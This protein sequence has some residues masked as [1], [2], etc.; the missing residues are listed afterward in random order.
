MVRLRRIP[1]I[2]HEL[3]RHILRQRLSSKL[4]VRLDR[5]Y[6]LILARKGE[7][8]VPARLPAVVHKTIVR[9]RP[10]LELKL[11][12]RLRRDLLRRTQNVRIEQL[13]LH[14]LGLRLTPIVESANHTKRV[15]RRI[16]PA[17]RNQIR[18]VRL[19]RDVRRHAHRRLVVEI[20]HVQDLASSLQ[21]ER[22]VGD[23][24]PGTALCG[25]VANGGRVIDNEF[26][27]KRGSYR[28]IWQI[29]RQLVNVGGGSFRQP[30]DVAMPVL[31][32]GVGLVLKRSANHHNVLVRIEFA[33]LDLDAHIHLELHG[34]LSKSKTSKG[35]D[36]N[37]RQSQWKSP[38]WHHRPSSFFGSHSN[39]NHRQT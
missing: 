39:L 35:E 14:H 25:A 28:R 20:H 11:R 5:T 29:H 6:R 34:I 15:L 23:A 2:H 36:K 33:L 17:L 16:K 8:V 27:L 18:H 24:L 26:V 21:S 31:N 22:P 38:L 19:E 1:N 4:N 32:G 12:P 30:E 37:Q 7:P 10:E 9:R 13:R 3:H